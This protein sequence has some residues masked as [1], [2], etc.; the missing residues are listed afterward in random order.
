MKP[1]I[2]LAILVLII[3][4]NA[5]A[6]SKNARSTGTSAAAGKKLY[7]TNCASCHGADGRGSSL[8]RGMGVHDLRSPDAAKMSVA[9][10]RNVIAEGR[11]N[12]PGWK[13]QLSEEQIAQVA[14]YVRAIQKRGK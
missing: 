5:E 10:T 9:D 7:V 13:N 11:G 8:G 4:S 12:M 14:A 1:A 6:R 2:V 3:G